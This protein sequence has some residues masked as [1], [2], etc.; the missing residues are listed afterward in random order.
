MLGRVK[1]SITPPYPLF[2]AL[3]K[4]FRRW[5]IVI[6]KSTGWVNYA[7]KCF[8]SKQHFIKP[9]FGNSGLESFSFAF[10]LFPSKG[11]SSKNSKQEIK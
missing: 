11:V 9:G 4:F 6:I 2:N 8:K 7:Q 10:V 1:A 5:E 3:S